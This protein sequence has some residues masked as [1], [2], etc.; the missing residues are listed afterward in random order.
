M[1]VA[2]IFVNTPGVHL[3]LEPL[4]LIPFLVKLSS[5]RKEWREEAGD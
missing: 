4:L 3:P 5:L 2:S 1:S